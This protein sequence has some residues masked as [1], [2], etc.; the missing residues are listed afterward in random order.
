MGH[1]LAGGV[2]ATSGCQVVGIKAALPPEPLPDSPIIDMHCHISGVGDDGSGCYINPRLMES[3]K[4]GPY[5]RAYGISRKILERDGDQAVVKQL[6][7]WVRASKHVDG[8]VVLALDMTLTSA[9][10]FDRERTEI[11]VPNEFVATICKRFDCLHYGAS[12]NPMRS[13]ALERLEQAKRD[14]AVLIKLLPAIQHIRLDDAR[15]IPYF[16]KLA[17][18]DLPL[19]THTGAERSFSSADH[20]A[21]D[22][23][24]LRLALDQGVT[25]IAAHMATTGSVDGERFMDRLLPLFQECPNLYA[26]ISSLTQV[27]KLGYL[28]EILSRHPEVHDRLLYGSDYPLINTLL[29]SPWYFPGNLSPG[30]MWRLSRTRNPWD[31]DVQLKQALGVP[32]SVFSRPAKLLGLSLAEK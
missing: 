5:L 10:E 32:A 4:A 27:N 11:Y 21:G 1:V 2:L 14:G 28:N 7:E 15:F 18:L 3:W 30:Q 19:L 12:V 6:V 24:A 8:V 25:V 9:G 23:V 22:P 31:Q 26:D 20:D 29:T 13:D 16:Q 17:E